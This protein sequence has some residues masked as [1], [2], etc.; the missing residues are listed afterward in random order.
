MQTTL[1]F[2]SRSAFTQAMPA[3]FISS[4]IVL[5]QIVRGLPLLLVPSGAQVSAVRVYALAFI[6]R[7]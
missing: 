3:F 6:R 4:E 2:A 5:L 1:S 7:V